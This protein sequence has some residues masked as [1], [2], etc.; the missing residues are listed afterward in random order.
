VSE[1][2]YG[3][4][5]LNDCKYGHD[6]HDSPEGAYA[7]LRLSLLRGPTM[8]DPL[9][10]LGEHRVCYSLMP[11]AGHWDQA[12]VGAAYSLNDPLIVYATPAD[13]LRSVTGDRSQTIGPLVKCD[14]ANIVVETVKLAEAGDSLIIRLYECLGK[15]GYARLRAGFPVREAWLTNLLEQD[16]EKQ[17]LEAGQIILYMKPFQIATVKLVGS[18]YLE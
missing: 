18:F 13:I 3:V 2:G 16:Q 4:S 12:T 10:D 9:A 7:V 17:T 15:R 8:P 14:Q 6:I 5:L 1:G 11:H